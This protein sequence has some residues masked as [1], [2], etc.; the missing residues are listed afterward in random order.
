MRRSNVC[1]CWPTTATGFGLRKFSIMAVMVWAT[2]DASVAAGFHRP[3][4]TTVL[5]RGVSCASS[6]SVESAEE[7]GTL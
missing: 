5:A 2:P 4:Q 7:D 3:Q 1:Q 6:E